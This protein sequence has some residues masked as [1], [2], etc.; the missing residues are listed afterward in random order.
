M[1]KMSCF[2]F[3]LMI[4]NSVFALLSE[5]FAPGH[6]KATSRQNLITCVL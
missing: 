6:K 2:F 4:G 5:I 3:F 1:L